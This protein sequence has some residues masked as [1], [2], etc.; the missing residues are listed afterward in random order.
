M[1]TRYASV[2]VVLSLLTLAP[3]TASALGESGEQEGE[4]TLVERSRV[5]TTRVIDAAP[6]LVE[7][8]RVETTRVVDAAP[9][10]NA[11]P[12]V[13]IELAFS[14]G[15]VMCSVTTTAGDYALSSEWAEKHRDYSPRQGERPKPRDTE[16][17]GSESHQFD[18][19]GEMTVLRGGSGVVV[20]Y[21]VTWRST[22]EST[23]EEQES[24]SVGSTTNTRRVKGRTLVKIGKTIHLASFDNEVL[25]VA[26]TSVD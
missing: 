8:S 5:E 4:P 25:A 26:V 14:V 2:I 1:K 16:S 3:L 17:T 11:A 15:G 22:S 20:A 19:T 7:R 12:M 6:T 10:Q 24:G 13:N 18:V 9:T 21:D 23:E